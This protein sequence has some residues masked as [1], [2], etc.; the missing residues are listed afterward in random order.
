M[1]KTTI[2]AVHCDL[3]GWV[4]FINKTNLRVWGQNPWV[5]DK[6]PWLCSKSLGPFHGPNP[7]V[8]DK[9]QSLINIHSREDTQKTLEEKILQDK[10]SPNTK[11]K[12]FIKFTSK[13]GI[14]YMLSRNKAILLLKKKTH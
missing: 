12:K 9:I 14:S 7:W 5:W 3:L 4:G 6:I 1:D 11:D 10:T 2:C 8:L 13:D